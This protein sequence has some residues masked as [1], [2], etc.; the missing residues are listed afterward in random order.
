M[1]ATPPRDT[2]DG[3]PLLAAED[4]RKRF[5]ALVVLDGVDLSVGAGEAVG[6]VGPNGAGQDDAARRARGRAAAERRHGPLPRRR[7][8]AAERG[9]ALPLGVGPHP[10]GPAAVRGHDRLR[11]RPRRH[12]DGRWPARAGGLRPHARGARL[13]RA[14]A[15][16]QPPRGGARPAVA[17]AA[18]DG[19]RAG[20]RPVGAAPRRDR[21]RADRRREPTSSS[22]RSRSCAAAGW[23]S[24]GS[25]TSSTRS[26]RSSERLVCMA[27]GPDHRRRR[28]RTRS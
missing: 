28:P 14:D 25:S 13:D 1:D 21:R 2:P 27:A 6:I 4:V 26:C 11:E 19:P 16:R 15:G 23:R 18:R 10:P 20:D 9:R 17:Q 24:S 3:T 12:D 22:R 5:G 7:R 8:H